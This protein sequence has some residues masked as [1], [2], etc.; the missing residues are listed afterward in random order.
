MQYASRTL[1]SRTFETGRAKE[2]L[3][4][5]FAGSVRFRLRALPWVDLASP[6]N[7]PSERQNPRDGDSRMLESF[8]STWRFRVRPKSFGRTLKPSELVKPKKG[9]SSVNHLRDL[10][11]T[12]SGTL[13]GSWRLGASLLERAASRRKRAPRK[14][15]RLCASCSQ[16]Q[17]A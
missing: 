1:P 6:D 13:P 5:V 15:T 7:G 4:K 10:P 16:E 17:R 2:S 14:A 8:T 12:R 3:N 11:I 9:V